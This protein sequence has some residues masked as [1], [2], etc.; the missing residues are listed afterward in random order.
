[1]IR[2]KDLSLRWK[3]LTAPVGLVLSLAC[4]GAFSLYAL[5]MTRD[6][7]QD[8]AK[9]PIAQARI[10][11]E[12]QTAAWA[13]HGRL[14]RLTA[15]AANESDQAKI[16]ASAA[17]TLADLKALGEKVTATQA[18]FAKEAS[19]TEAL[20]KLDAAMKTYS[21]QG[22]NVADMA[23]SDAGSS[24][25]F[26]M[27]AD[28]TFRTL[29]EIT[30]KLATDAQARQ[31]AGTAGI[32]AI[33]D[34]E[35]MLVMVVLALSALVGLVSA[36][37]IARAISRPVIA[38]SRAL[39]ELAAGRHAQLE[40]DH[41]RDEIGSMAASYE[42]LAQ[43]LER[44]SHLE[45]D[46]AQADIA[47]QQRSAAIAEI[48]REVATVVDAAVAG[49]FSA[50]A[51]AANVDPDISKLVDG[52]N[53]INT[54]V[55]RATRDIGG[56]LEALAQGDLTH[57]VETSYQGRFGELAASLNETVA[58][59]SE[60]VETIQSTSIDVAGAAREI[61]SGAD[62]LSKRTEDQASSLEQTA[63]TTEELAASVKASA[64]S[65]AQ[66]VRLSEEA[67]LVAQDGGAIVTRA[68]DAMSRIEEASRRISDITT[69][70][71]DI[72]FQTNLLALNAAVEAARAGDAGK[73]F[74]VVASEVRTL[75]QRSSEAAKDITTLIN[76]SD[77]EVA[78]GVKLVRAAG[79][80]LGKIV[81]ASQRVAATV[82]EISSA[83]DEQANGIDEMSQAVAHMDDMTQ[84]NAALAEESAA[85]AQ[86]LAG[87]IA[88]LNQLVATFRTRRGGLA[89][90]YSAPAPA[91]SRAA[92]A[93][94]TE[95]ARL[96][97]LAQDAF[98]K[99]A[100]PAR[101]A[102]AARNAPPPAAPAPARARRAGGGA[103]PG[104][105]WDEF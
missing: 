70:I 64:Q 81:D 5:D 52:I 10:A 71:D 97:K 43:A 22:K 83:A 79:D 65:S 59:L 57:T 47:V 3:V 26:M 61:T 30:A 38:M 103:Q 80:A 12:L 36:P 17:A 34:R 39:E 82:S 105:G 19:E 4:L 27:N 75:A 13:T 33:V 76:S 86:S 8:L 90:A 101:P 49:D 74:A 78:D 89:A 102:A 23:D 6:S 72:A 20:A 94:A 55:D 37:M 66:A 58:R 56:A 16:Q 21:K 41:R 98:A 14:Y 46:K 24:L 42:V 7:F 28:R 85:S 92:P 45:A 73:G 53:A 29:E 95:P 35:M 77:A 51:Q 67:A 48:V 1:M 104:A 44:R 25:M 32:N 62:D 60:T 18:T 11:G 96:R 68:V 40:K 2:F 100:K 50:R 93:P 54:V 69:V 99:L 91:A 63:A 84:Q 9:G 88:Q 15:T 31:T 87:Q